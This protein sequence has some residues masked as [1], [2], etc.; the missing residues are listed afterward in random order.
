[1]TSEYNILLS[2]VIPCYNEKNHIEEC[3]KSLIC[4]EFI[5]GDFEIVVVDGMSTD[6]TRELLDKYCSSYSN[7]KVVDNKKKYTPHALNLGIDNSRGNFISILGAHSIYDKNYLAN[8]YS[9]FLKHPEADCTGGPIISDGKTTFGKAAAM[10][11]SHP[12]GVGNAKHRFP[13][14]E[15]YAEGACFPTFRKKVFEKIGKYDERLIKNQD[16][17]LN[18]RLSK[19]GG[20]VYISP[21]A[22]ATY[23]VRNTSLSLVKQYYHYGFWRVA[24]T[25]KHKQPI[26]IRQI[27]PAL[28]V[29]I[30][31]LSLISLVLLPS[32]YKVFGFAVPVLYFGALLITTLTLI[33]KKNIVVLS[34]FPIA[35][36]ILHFSY[37]IGFI[38]G[39]FSGRTKL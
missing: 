34:L 39:C 12:L 15:G 19:S 30:F 38:A 20:K 8:S 18:F 25:R 36:T 22:S 35:V 3:I 29:I 33:G 17:E 37:G 6:G 14:Y 11:M 32:E 31:C 10:A 2:V 26:A 27:I 23:F 7:I 4:Q 28:F 16:D 24:V 13:D 5:Y 1:M 9:L 21:D